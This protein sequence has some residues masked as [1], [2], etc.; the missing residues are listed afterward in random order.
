MAD[1]LIQFA[2]DA[3]NR[4]GGILSPTPQTQHKLVQALPRTQAKADSNWDHFLVGEG[5]NVSLLQ[6]EVMKVITEC[7]AAIS[8][9]PMTFTVPQ[10]PV[11]FYGDDKKDKLLF[12]EWMEEMITH[13]RISKLKEV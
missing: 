4:R 7:L 9:P 11:C 2:T 5:A 3:A 13:T 10:D 6:L 12:K 1:K 8:E